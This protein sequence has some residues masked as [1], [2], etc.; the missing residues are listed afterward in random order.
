MC[1]IQFTSKCH[2][3]RSHGFFGSEIRKRKEEERD[4][5]CW[6]YSSSTSNAL[7]EQSFVDLKPLPREPMSNSEHSLLLPITGKKPKKVK[8]FGGKSEFSSLFLC[9]CVALHCKKDNKQRFQLKK[10]CFR[11]YEI[12]QCFFIR[13]GIGKSL[14]SGYTN[15][16][17]CFALS[18]K[19]S[20]FATAAEGKE[21][22][23]PSD[24]PVIS[25]PSN[26]E[27]TVHVGYDPQT[28]EFTWPVV[29]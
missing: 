16:R 9:I 10:G 20:I 19:M 13:D 23:R 26:F 25:L 14:F 17:D 11:I 28:G 4:V 8:A 7:R 5:G 29:V 21:K 24:K 15:V 12:P 27:H 18:H 22:D 3:K 2:L 1:D 6:R